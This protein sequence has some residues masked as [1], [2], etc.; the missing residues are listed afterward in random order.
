AASIAGFVFQFAATGAG[1]A[2]EAASITPC[3]PGTPAPAMEHVG[4]ANFVSPGGRFT[5]RA[6]TVVFLLEWAY[7]IQPWQHSGGPG[8]LSNERFDV[9]AKADHDAPEDEMK[10]MARTLLAER[11]GL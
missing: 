7:G 3:P 1:P 6:T 9:V 10:Q 8:W 11:F 4:I 5:A 2:F